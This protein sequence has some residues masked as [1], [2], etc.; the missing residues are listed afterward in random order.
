VD[1]AANGDGKELPC[2]NFKL[3]TLHGVPR[4]MG[5]L[6]EAMRGKFEMRGDGHSVSAS[7]SSHLGTPDPV[8][9]FALATS[10]ATF[11]QRLLQDAHKIDKY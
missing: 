10:L 2:R 8:F 4:R 6:T 9:S 5:L 11:H 7:H 1:L 3:E